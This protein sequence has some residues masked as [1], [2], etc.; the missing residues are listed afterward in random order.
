MLCLYVVLFMLYLYCFFVSCLCVCRLSCV[1]LFCCICSVLFICSFGLVGFC[2]YVMCCLCLFYLFYVLCVYFCGACCFMVFVCCGCLL[3]CCYYCYCVSCVVM[4]M[5]ICFCCMLVLSFLAFFEGTDLRGNRE[6]LKKQKK[7]GK[8]NDAG[9]RGN[10]SRIYP[11]CRG[12]TCVRASETKRFPSTKGFPDLRH[13]FDLQC[14][15]QVSTA[16][17]QHLHLCNI[18]C[19]CITRLDLD[20]TKLTESAIHAR[21]F[22][23][24]LH[25]WEQTLLAVWSL[26]YRF[27]GRVD[28]ESGL[29]SVARSSRRY[30]LHCPTQH[31]MIRI[32]YIRVAVRLCLSGR[33]YVYAYCISIYAFTYLFLQIDIY[34]SDTKTY[35]HTCIYV[36]ITYTRIYT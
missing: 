27:Q 5:Y 23:R 33:V 21:A 28:A 34:I 14:I 18:L 16:Y 25:R 12:R 10:V 22:S 29:C 7:K 35:T 15:C 36:V 8:G 2:F 32:S 19:I 11:T 9:W 13:M 17:L 20:K 31:D 6:H 1:L 30:N 4:F 24:C 26:F 3:L